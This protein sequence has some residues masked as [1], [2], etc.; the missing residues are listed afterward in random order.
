MRALKLGLNYDNKSTSV[1]MKHHAA[2]VACR[3]QKPG[4]NRLGAQF[5]GCEACC[6]AVSDGFGSDLHC[7]A[8]HLAVFTCLAF[9]LEHEVQ[10]G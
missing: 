5:V 6:D 2:S 1:Y 10:G 3:R 8:A 9:V 4:K 7:H